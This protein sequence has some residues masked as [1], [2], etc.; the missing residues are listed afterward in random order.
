MLFL[1][2][3]WL[4][5]NKKVEMVVTWRTLTSVVWSNFLQCLRALDMLQSYLP[6]TSVSQ[7]TSDVTSVWSQSGRRCFCLTY[8]CLTSV[9]LSRTSGLTREQIGLG[10]L[11]CMLKWQ[12]HYESDRNWESYQLLVI[13]RAFSDRRGLQIM[14]WSRFA[15]SN[16]ARKFDSHIAYRTPR[17]TVRTPY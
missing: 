8:V 1:A 11:K 13:N 4:F 15:V 10:R 6:V 7:F 2:V 5:S 3:F 9:C 16:F 17:R 12:R 14:S